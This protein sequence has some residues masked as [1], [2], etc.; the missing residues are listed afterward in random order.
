MWSMSDRKTGDEGFPCKK[1]DN[2]HLRKLRWSLMDGR[3]RGAVWGLNHTSFVSL[4]LS[5]LL[6]E[7]LRGGSG[8]FVVLCKAGVWRRPISASCLCSALWGVH[9]SHQ[10]QRT[11]DQ[12][13]IRAGVP[14]GQDETETSN[15]PSV[16]ARRSLARRL[17]AEAGVRPLAV[18]GALEARAWRGWFSMQPEIVCWKCSCSAAFCSSTTSSVFSTLYS[19]PRNNGGAGFLHRPPPQSEPPECPSCTHKFICVFV[20]LWWSF[21]VNKVTDSQM[22]TGLVS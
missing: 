5:V 22:K 21:C 2:K 3:L 16:R 6:A 7:H 9:M 12:L 13:I 4:L 18:S 19:E 17:W 11:W 14:R 20:R 8:R 15:Y 10:W 1:H